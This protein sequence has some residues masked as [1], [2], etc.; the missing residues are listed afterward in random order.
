[1]QQLREFAAGLIE[2]LARKDGELR[3]RQLK[4]DQLTHEMAVSSG[5]S[6]PPV[7]SSCTV[8]NACC[9]TRRCWPTWRPWR[10]SLPRCSRKWRRRRKRSRAGAAAAA[11]ARNLRHEPE[12]TVC[13]CGCPLQAYRRGREREA[14]LH[15]GGV[16]GRATHSRQVGLCAV[17]DAHAGAGAGAD[18]RQGASHR[19]VAGPGPGGEVCGPPTA[20]SSR[21]SSLRGPAWPCRARRSPSGSASAACTC[22]P[23]SRRCG[24]RC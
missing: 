8:N 1:M 13:S 11:P 22:S 12:R 15:A 9:L 21:R 16:P 7:A 2:S 23:W 5:G 19:R 17:P 24:R 4:I 10:W 18:H 20:L 14:R 6:L 3:T